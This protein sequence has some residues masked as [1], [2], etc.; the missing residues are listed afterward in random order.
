[1]N[2]HTE[3]IKDSVLEKIRNEK[4]QM[5]SKVYFVCRVSVLFLATLG[6]LITS[7]LLI[8]YII[9]SITISDRLFLLGFGNQGIQAFLKLFPW[10][11]VVLEV[12][13][14]IILEQIVRKF[15]WAYRRP[16]IWILLGIGIV[17]SICSLI[18]TSSAFHE[19]L[20]IQSTQLGPLK[21]L[22][23]DIQKP[24]GKRDIFHGQIVDI[25][26][27]TFIITDL[28]HSP[29]HTLETI[30]VHI[31]KTTKV[32]NDLRIGDLVF[33]AGELNNGEITAYGI[34]K[35]Q[36]KI[37]FQLHLMK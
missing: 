22:Y 19:R 25:K 13:L 16:L 23:Q 30:K 32:F 10:H 4:V 35:W 5:H 33:V 2:K 34:R 37:Q 27:Y 26:G 11:L 7:S 14:I 21:N 36:P 31:A 28:D 1:M 3:H 24:S 9:F 12:V 17:S 6:L 20:F 8:S 18:I 15:R 29:S